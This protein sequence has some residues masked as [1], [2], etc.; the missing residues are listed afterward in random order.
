M[1]AAS[2]GGRFH[3][4][5]DAQPSSIHTNPAPSRD[6]WPW[7]ALRFP[8]GSW[9]ICPR[10]CESLNAEPNFPRTV[11]RQAKDVAPVLPQDKP[12][13]S[14]PLNGLGADLSNQSPRFDSV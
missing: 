14:F 12:T 7:G 2:N 9:A 8:Q 1:G 6:R 5:G 10:W 3:I 4:E 13:W 11:R